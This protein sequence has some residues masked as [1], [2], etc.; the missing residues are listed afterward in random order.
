MSINLNQCTSECSSCIRRYISKHR[1]KRGDSFDI[2]CHGI[3]LEYL[4]ADVRSSVSG[5][6]E[7]AISMIDAVTWAGKF[8]DWHCYDPIGE[9]WKRKSLEGS[10]PTGL[11]QYEEGV[12]LA[13]KS[14][15]NR[16]YQGEMLRCSAKYKVFR[17]G[18]QAGKTEV[19]CVSVL[20]NVFTHKNFRCVIIA[21]YD[22]QVELIFE[23]LR[24]FIDNN[25]MLS[26]SVR[27]KVKK[28]THQIELHNGSIIIGFTAGT[29]SKQEAGASRGQ[30][31]HMLVFDEADYLSAGDLNAAL[32]TITNFPEA[33]VWMSSTPAGKR[34]KFFESCRD[35]M[36]RE[37]H[38][39]SQINP[40][41][42]EE[43]ER[44]FRSQ[45]TEDGYKH[46]I[47]AEFGEQEEGVY[48]NKYI[49]LAQD[50][51]DYGD[52]K[53]NPNWIYM[54]GVDWNDVKIGTTLA[55]V[56]FEPASGLFRLV[57]KVVMTRS[58]RTQLSACQKVAE[59]NR[60][61][62]PTMIYVDK[63]FGTTQI[64]VLQKFGY[65]SLAGEGANSPNARLRNIVKG[66]DFGGSIEIRDL[67]TKQPISKKAKPFLIE[68]S[69]RR[70]EQL[71]F[72]YPS[73]DELFTKAL[74]GYIVKRITTTGVPVYE[75]QDESVGDHF[76]DAVNLALVAFTLEKSAF[77]APK[78]EARISFSA[79][80]GA[81]LRGD[82]DPRKALQEKEAHR[83]KMGRAAAVEGGS[84][85]LV[86]PEHGELPMNTASV[87]G[88]RGPVKLWSWPG[89]GR[90][91]PR[92]RVRS[93]R[94]A[95]SD[96]SQRLNRQPSRRGS[97]RPRRKNI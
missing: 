88:A 31:A 74:Q 85:R 21:P 17:I 92:P 1:L 13:G 36:Y 87:D 43:R 5:D 33:T 67:F 4:P 56:G 16:P 82:K 78:H 3:P 28:P 14:V 7:L 69:V 39:P 81:I 66:Y 27:R 18:R 96:A 10:M 83:P 22:S 37:F 47:L 57:D 2:P 32:A 53:P 46:E 71:T 42:T 8:L 15:F 51:Y 24:T 80:I 59:L 90:D 62:N 68:N 60:F 44:F 61:W 9:H 49:E 97:S 86:V 54:M 40:N 70:F 48:Q 64:E 35:P 93:L 26:N 58:E 75:M 73:S 11:A 6:P 76:L 29:K 77:G 79:E 30:P 84:D 41:W 52:Y 34:E 23:R 65:D 12:A 38:F 89:F 72:K 45:L 19:L 95:M 63:G 50:D 94:E 25:A 20:H 55:V 91:A